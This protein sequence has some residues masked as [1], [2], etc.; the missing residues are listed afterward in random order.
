MFGLT[1]ADYTKVRKAAGASFGNVI[2]G[3][4]LLAVNV[5]TVVGAV[6]VIFTGPIW[7]MQIG[8]P[9]SSPSWSTSRQASPV[10]LLLAQSLVVGRGHESGRSFPRPDW[11]KSTAVVFHF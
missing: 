7:M 8:R 3:F 2:A 1:R 4:A 5:V 9:Q 10:S 6:L 11:A